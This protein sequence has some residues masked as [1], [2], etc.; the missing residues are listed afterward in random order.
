MI[1]L[2]LFMATLSVAAYFLTPGI[3]EETIKDPGILKKKSIRK[4]KKTELPSKS[5]VEQGVG[6]MN[7]M[8]EP[9]E[10]PN[11]KHTEKDKKQDQEI[12]NQVV[13]KEF[14]SSSYEDSSEEEEGSEEEHSESEEEEAKP[15]EIDKSNIQDFEDESPYESVQSKIEKN[16]AEVI[17]KRPSNQIKTG[18]KA[19][20]TSPRDKV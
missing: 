2:L 10:N 1:F 9:N 19:E 13:S 8:S 14:N 6:G 20:N 18:D 4:D 16:K 15:Q 11:P 5:K 7:L 12:N 17:I 3:K